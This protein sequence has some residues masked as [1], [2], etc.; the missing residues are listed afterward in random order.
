MPILIGIALVVSGAGI[1]VLL[2]WFS[3]RNVELTPDEPQA[4]K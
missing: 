3:L 1:G 4:F 2:C